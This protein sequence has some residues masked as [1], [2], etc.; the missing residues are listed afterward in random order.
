VL[1]VINLLPAI[2]D[3]QDQDGQAI[4]A[5]AETYLGK[6][7]ILLDDASLASGSVQH[8]RISGLPLHSQEPMIEPGAPQRNILWNFRMSL[9]YAR[10]VQGKF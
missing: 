9:R 1:K 10:T 8:G 2:V 4:S 3:T 5:F 7:L 6:L